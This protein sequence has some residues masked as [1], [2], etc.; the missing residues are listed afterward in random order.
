M[1][2]AS[3]PALSFPPGPD[4][5][6][7]TGLG[8]SAHRDALPCIRMQADVENQ[9]YAAGV[10]AAWISK[11]GCATRA[12]DIKELQKHLVAVG[13]LPE[14]ILRETDNFPLPKERVAD[15]VRRVVNDYDG[16]EIL[17]AQFDTAQPLL[18]QALATAPETNRLIYAHILGMMGDGAGAQVLADAVS[19]RHWDQGWRYTGMG[20][21]GPCM[22]PLDSL[23]IALGRTRSQAGVKPILEKVGQL[24]ANSEFSHFRAIAMALE[25]LAD[26]S[27]AQPLAKLLGKPGLGGH[28]VTT[29]D[30]ALVEAD[31]RS[32]TDTTLR[33]QA[34][35][36][37][38]LARALYR[39]G[40]YEGLGEKT[41]REYSRDLHGH[42]ARHAKAVL[43]K[44]AGPVE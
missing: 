30:A 26:K 6:I 43:Q 19:A 44:A 16:L 39:C 22:S 37:L 8:V 21:F 2:R 25:T 23:L 24:D 14:S 3:R 18:R 36:E 27:A 13:N 5:V 17:L 29:I 28:S 20:Q 33:N 40:D 35:K 31:P 7:V 10:A 34:L 42:Y 38:Y 11:K 41:L 4:G 12:L 15:A 32:R 9:G 1:P